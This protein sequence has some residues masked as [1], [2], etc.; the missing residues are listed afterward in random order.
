MILISET[1]AS[2]AGKRERGEEGKRGRGKEG[3]GKEGRGK[4]GKG[5]ASFP[6]RSSRLPLLPGFA[7]KVERCH[8]LVP[9]SFTFAATCPIKR[10]SWMP[11]PCAV[12]VHVFITSNKREA[13]R[14]KRV[15]SRTF[16]LSSS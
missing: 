14:D 15:A 1:L 16:Y 13:P 10:N 7:S 5:D 12:E 9:W 3:R 11:R 6:F 2:T 8:G 4:E